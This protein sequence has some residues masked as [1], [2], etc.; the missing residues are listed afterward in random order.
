VRRPELRLCPGSGQAA[1]P[2]LYL[3]LTEEGKTHSVYVPP[4]QG[5]VVKAA[6]AAWLRFLE[7]GSRIAAR[8]RARFLQDLAREKHKAKAAK[9]SS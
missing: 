4:A 8:N 1:G 7:I 9:D 2:H 6:H 3:K 5:R